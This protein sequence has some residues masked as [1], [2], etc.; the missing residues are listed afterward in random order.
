MNVG[1]WIVGGALGGLVGA[2]VWAA[3][4]YYAER[5]FAIVAWAIGGL[6]G[7]GVRSQARDDVGAGPGVTAVLIAVAAIMLGKFLAISLIVDNLQAKF[8][9]I[10]LPEPTAE[11]VQVRFANEIT[12][13]RQHKG[14]EG[15]KV[16]LPNDEDDEGPA[17]G[18]ALTDFPPDIAKAAADRWNKMSP[19]DRDKAFRE[20]KE[21][22]DKFIQALGEGGLV[23]NAGE[24]KWNAFKESFGAF[25]ILFVVLAVFTAFRI[26]SGAQE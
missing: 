13:E 17:G 18:E 11:S 8:G 1:R 20:Q 26:G 14:G 3:L 6:V 4:A 21:M 22:N 23:G 5:E 25:D 19:A 10:N 7:M 2:A 12:A 16:A 15:G 24:L 9:D